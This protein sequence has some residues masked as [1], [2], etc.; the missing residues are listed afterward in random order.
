MELN[1]K[2]IGTSTM[3]RNLLYTFAFIFCFSIIF[4]TLVLAQTFDKNEISESKL[5]QQVMQPQ[6]VAHPNHREVVL[7]SFDLAE[8]A[9]FLDTS[10]ITHKE[11]KDRLEAG[12][13]SED[14][15]SIPG[16]VGVHFPLPW[17]QGPDFDFF[18]LYPFSK[19][20]YGNYTD[21]LSGWYRGLNH[22]YDPVLGFKWPNADVTTLEW[23]NY[24]GN[25]YIWDNAVNL[26]NSGNKAEAYQCLGHVLHL[27]SDLSVPSHI[28]VVDHGISVVSINSGTVIDPDHMVL[29]VDEYELALSG[30]VSIPGIVDFIPNLLSQ[31]RSSLDSVKVNDIPDFSNWEDYLKELGTYTYN[32]SIV[33]NYYLA[34]IQNGG[35]G[36]AL[37]EDSVITQPIEYGITPPVELNGRWV[38]ISLKS[39]ASS[40]GTIVPKADLIAMCNYLVPK[41]VEYCAGLL[42]HFN[43]IVTD[44]ADEQ[45]LP[46]KYSLEQNYPNPFNP[47]TKISWQSPVGSFQTLKIY[48]VL[49]NEVA[50]LVDEY[51]PV[52]SYEVE[53]N[54]IGLPSGVYF[55]QLTIPALQSKNGKTDGFIE[56]KKMIILR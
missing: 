40:N 39:T 27:L 11:I 17:N 37:N 38:Q 6:Y 52:G 51:K 23:A 55:Y 1:T 53:W 14:F 29:I 7:K 35:W 45:S 2:E 3:Q 13:Y 22:G 30:G 9:G 24:T 12:A 28:K 32:N 5:Y 56:T 8:V 20:P 34:P 44:V 15:E 26:Y 36:F 10:G 41:A 4:E 47:R 54:A 49:G 48:D 50:T 21:T 16:D 33:N 19:I 18:G 46:L 42:I 25:S 31:F 43:R